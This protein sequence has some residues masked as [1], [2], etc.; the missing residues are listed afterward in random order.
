MGLEIED[1]LNFAPQMTLTFNIQA[2]SSSFAV[3]VEKLF[4]NS[5]CEDSGLLTDAVLEG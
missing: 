1:E 4:G 2:P 3:R 5:R